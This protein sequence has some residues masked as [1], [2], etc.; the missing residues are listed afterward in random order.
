MN[1]SSCASAIGKCL[2]VRSGF[3]SPKQEWIRKRICLLADRYLPFLH[4]LQQCTLDLRRRAVD[5]VS[6]NQVRKNR[7]EFG[8][9]FASA[10]IVNQRA[11]QIAGKRSGVNCNL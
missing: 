6:Q 4:R 8:C 9:K 10:R 11:Y 1:R 3:A 2:P 5:F 7:A